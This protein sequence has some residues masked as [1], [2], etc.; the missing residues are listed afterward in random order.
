MT[1]ANSLVGRPS[2][3]SRIAHVPRYRR[4]DVVLAIA[5]FLDLCIAVLLRAPQLLEPDDFAYRASIVALSRGH[6]LLSNA[7]YLALG[8]QLGSAASSVGPG[9][10]G[11]IQQ[12]DLLAN[13]LWISEKN[14]GYAFLAVPFEWLG[15]PRLT[16]PFYGA[17]GCLGP[18]FGA[19]RW[20]GR[21]GGAFAVVL[22]CCSGAALAFAWRATTETLAD[23]SLVAADAGALVWSMLATDAIQRRRRLVGLAAILALVA[24]TFTR[25][26]DVVAL[27]VAILP[28]IVLAR[29]V[30][31]RW[32]TVHVWAIGLV[33]SGAGILAF[34]QYA[35]G[36]WNKTDYA[37]GEI[38]L[39]TEHT[40]AQ[41][42]AHVVP[43]GPG[44]PHVAARARRRRLDRRTAH[45]CPSQRRSGR[46]RS[47][48]PR[49]RDRG[50]RRP[51][52]DRERGVRSAACQGSP[53]AHMT[54]PNEPCGSSTKLP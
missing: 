11:A 37:A 47:A 41:P 54:S 12:W 16:P 20:L 48:T 6:I 45:H 28:V 53:T 5:A 15:A 51:G 39:L 46:A 24:A 4:A 2:P 21:W 19:R 1:T 29:P 26:T 30:G 14:P 32:R 18:W 35:Y 22:F 7:Q 9:G 43:S 34:N 42:A 36:A 52:H 3:D 17:L 27:G 8:H 31:I 10:G 13:G 25:Y 23:A 40:L 33:L 44:D 38:H 50:R 49:R